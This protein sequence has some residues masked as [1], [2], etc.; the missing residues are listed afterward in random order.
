MPRRSRGTSVL[1]YEPSN[2]G[3]VS[4]YTHRLASNLVLAG[5]HVAVA[6]PERAQLTTHQRQY[7]VMVLGK[8]FWLK[9]MLSRFSDRS[10]QNFVYR[11]IRSLQEVC[12]SRLEVAARKVGLPIIIWVRLKLLVAILR[13]RPDIVHFQWLTDPTEEYYF[14]KVLRLFRFTIVYTAHNLLPHGDES[15]DSRLRY[16]RIYRVADR[17]IVHA[18]RS[19]DDMA[20]QFHIELAKIAVIPHGPD[21][22]FFEPSRLI[23]RSAARKELDITEDNTVLLFFGLIRRYKGL[24]YLVEA[25]A[26][27]K[28]RFENAIL[29][30]AGM[31]SEADS[32]EFT[33]YRKVLKALD[34]RGDVRRI[35][36]YIPDDQVGG[37]FMAS[38]LVVLPYLKT[39]TSGVLMAAYAAGRPVVATDTGALGEIVVPGRTGMLVPPM[40]SH[41]LAGAIITLLEDRNALKNMGRYARHLAD[42]RYSWQR[43]ATQTLDLYQSVLAG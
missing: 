40:D 18:E 9:A 29:L 17:L 5:V 37:L 7:R 15:D 22:S 24:E 3:G 42:T 10:R 13:E 23:S 1:L 35:N 12:V 41:A 36:E 28:A 16:Q 30:I 21:D 43:A 14:M 38:D 2:G 6:T 33:Y 26:E 31:V 8:R 27:V 4:L 34:G 39:D 11:Q 19:R 25:F 20:S 32:E